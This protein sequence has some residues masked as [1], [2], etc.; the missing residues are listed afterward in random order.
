MAAL[1]A[2][3]GSM[4]LGSLL[5]PEP[6]CLGTEEAFTFLPNTDPATF[7]EEFQNSSSVDNRYL[8]HLGWVGRGCAELPYFSDCIIPGYSVDK[9]SKPLKFI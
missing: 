8:V 3:Y 5:A 4:D 9:L 1:A 2:A 6:A 7:V